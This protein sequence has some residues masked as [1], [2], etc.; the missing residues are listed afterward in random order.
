VLGHLAA[1]QTCIEE[2]PG[3]ANERTRAAQETVRR[4]L[5]GWDDG[6]RAGELVDPYS[7]GGGGE[8]WAFVAERLHVNA[9]F[10]TFCTSYVVVKFPVFTPEDG[11]PRV[12]ARRVHR[13]RAEYDRRRRLGDAPHL[14]HVPALRFLPCDRLQAPSTA[15]TIAVETREATIPVLVTPLQVTRTGGA[16]PAD[17]ESLIPEDGCWS[18][19]ELLNWTVVARGLARGLWSMH[20]RGWAHNDLKPQN[21]VLYESRGTWHEVNLI[22][23]GLV[24]P[25][26][27]ATVVGAGSGTPSYWRL[28]RLEVAIG[29][30]TEDSLAHLRPS[31]EDLYA[32][33]VMLVE[34][35]L[36]KKR[37]QELRQAARKKPLPPGADETRDRSIFSAFY[38]AQS[39]RQQVREEIEDKSKAELRRFLRNA[40]ETERLSSAGSPR[41][42]AFL[43]CQSFLMRDPPGER[44][45]DPSLERPT[46][47]MLRDFLT[48]V[49]MR[50][51]ALGDPQTTATRLLV[52]IGASQSASALKSRR[53]RY[54]SLPEGTSAPL[55]I[56][57]CAELVKDGYVRH[58]ISTIRARLNAMCAAEAF[59][60]A[61]AREIAWGL[62][63]L[64]GVLLPRD[65]RY[66]DAWRALQKWRLKLDAF[67]S[68]QDPK[69]N[70]SPREILAWWLDCLQWRLSRASHRDEKSGYLCDRRQLL[71]DV[72][73][74]DEPLRPP[75]WSF[76]DPAENARAIAWTHEDALTR[77][78]MGDGELADDSHV[79]KQAESYQQ[80][81]KSTQEAVHAQLQ[82][83]R[84][85]LY[86]LRTFDPN[87]MEG[88][89]SSALLADSPETRMSLEKV[90][91]TFPDMLR[92]WTL[93]V[94][95]SLV[96]DLHH[97]Y[98]SAMMVVAH[99]GHRVFGSRVAAEEP[100]PAP[101]A[102]EPTLGGGSK[103]PVDARPPQGVPAAGTPLLPTAGEPSGGRPRSSSLRT[104]I[105]K[106]LREGYDVDAETV[107]STA[108]ECA[109]AA[110][111]TY[112]DIDAPLLAWR[113][114]QTAARCL[115]ACQ[116][117]G[118]RLDAVRWLQFAKND[119]LLHKL[120]APG[121]I[122]T[123][124]DMDEPEEPRDST[125]RA[126][127]GRG[128]DPLRVEIGERSHRAIEEAIEEWARGAARVYKNTAG[129]DPGAFLSQAMFGRYGAAL[130][131]LS[132][133]S[134]GVEAARASGEWREGESNPVEPHSGE[135]MSRM[136]DPIRE[137]MNQPPSNRRAFTMIEIECGLGHDCAAAGERGVVSLLPHAT[138]VWG[139]ESMPW[140]ARRAQT[141]CEAL[142]RVHIVKANI[143]GSEADWRNDVVT[144][145]G[146]RRFDVVWMHDVLVRVSNRGKVLDRAFDLLVP[147]GCLMM[148]DW[149]QTRQMSQEEWRGLCEV[150]WITGPETE[151]GHEKLLRAARFE[152]VNISRHR[153]DMLNAFAWA[154]A[155]PLRFMP[156]G[157]A[158]MKS[159]LS[160]VLRAEQSFATLHQLVKEGKL[161]WIWVTARRPLQ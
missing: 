50:I 1:Y 63:L 4:A 122:L 34:V 124:A 90:L 138:E 59:S 25:D 23:F 64:A 99:Q 32:L 74:P 40:T 123:T 70:G 104:V 5:D 75:A 97:E 144:K 15:R 37:V 29:R 18:S 86:R 135:V 82:M 31:T 101:A 131:V 81:G 13:L 143:L 84:W 125:P 44:Q 107:L 30:R 98:A 49:D 157:D 145:L 26:M 141:R 147:G 62:R 11:S 136:L 140:C 114:L 139:V 80:S 126:G 2:H 10:G 89:L 116:A 58:G 67:P 33:G 46:L 100:K 106:V 133:G 129:S 38:Y 27:P 130:E 158:I 150:A 66:R 137:Q 155:A 14:G 153:E 159:D 69:G 113:A 142:E 156:G 127:R 41:S 48:N 111:S 39:I 149:V 85:T 53:E 51:V 7:I 22:D 42:V 9:T 103:T 88:I 87:M 112:T 115:S 77:A 21:V 12:D 93:A 152:R 20:G 54:Y 119:Y 73:P 65:R 94:G 45:D 83:V 35:L 105:E 24:E 60:L 68:E 28:E 161:D 92:M 109:L 71:S 55:T 160:T 108:A 134:L 61:D 17:L 19:R 6:S 72:R 91:G 154:K 78:M 96:T 118:Q 43:L 47:T 8:G 151:E 3:M 52:N 146:G 95:W 128:E 148:T 16:V 120:N 56:K 79:L 102:P 121:R 110:A 132:A 36:G 76:G 57:E 117:P